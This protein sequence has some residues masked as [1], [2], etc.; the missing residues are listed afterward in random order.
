VRVIAF[1]IIT[2]IAIVG[3]ALAAVAPAVAACTGCTVS[4]GT[5][6]VPFG[7]YDPFAS[8]NLTTIGGIGIVASAPV[9]ATIPVTVALSSGSGTYAQRHFIG[10]AMNY[11]LTVAPGGATFGDGTTGTQT[12]SVLA[13]ATVIATTTNVRVYGT[14]PAGQR[15]FAAGTYHDTITVTLTF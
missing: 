9:V 11:A 15:S 12:V 7:N 3:I 13:V 6:S 14:I 4:V 1:L 5:A 8:T 2:L 10:P